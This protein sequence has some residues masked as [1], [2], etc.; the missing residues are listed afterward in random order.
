MWK[1][2]RVNHQYVLLLQNG[3]LQIVFPISIDKDGITP[4]LPATTRRRLCPPGLSA[5]TERMLRH[6]IYHQRLEGGYESLVY[7][8]RLKGC[9]NTLFTN[10]NWKEGTPHWFIS[11]D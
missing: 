11:Y 6:P 5:T 3:Y 8:L 7:Q 9:Y 1:P 4:Y 10:A 2:N